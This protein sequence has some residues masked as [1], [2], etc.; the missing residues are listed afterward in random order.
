VDQQ[1]CV[2]QRFDPQCAEFPW[3]TLTVSFSSCNQGTLQF[4]PGNPALASGSMPISRLTMLYNSSCTGG[5]SGDTNA[6]SLSGE[7][8]QFMDNTGLVPAAQGKM[9]FDETVARSEFSVE[10]EDLPAGAYT[11]FVDNVA[12]G[13]INVV[14]EIGGTNGELEFRSPVEPGKVLLDFDPP[15][16]SSRS[17]A[18]AAYFSARR[19][20]P[21][22]RRLRADGFG[23]PP[24]GN[25]EYRLSV[26]PSGNNGPAEGRAGTARR[27]YRLQC[28]TRTCRSATTDW[29]SAA[30][31]REHQCARSRG[32][33]RDRIPQSTGTGHF[34]S[35]SI[36]DSAHRYHFRRKRGDLRFVP[37]DPG[38]SGNGGGTSGGNSGG[39]GGDDHGSGDDD[40]DGDDHGVEDSVIGALLATGAARSPFDARG[41]SRW[42]WMT[43]GTDGALP[44]NCPLDF[45]M[46]AATCSP[47][48]GCAFTRSRLPLARSRSCFSAMCRLS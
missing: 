24:F 45:P 13:T 29:S 48:E 28:R 30:S 40:G 36:R 6:T 41:L 18:A 26:E 37:D 34:G 8:V 32:T 11:L 35:I 44:C 23:S 22:R 25:A 15:G 2:W 39:Q 20:A 21:Q 17:S 1:R 16:N 5:I 42:I 10:A 19:W 3:G 7:I 38:A 33:E 27:S 31:S 43:T 47:R 9:K 12:R 46:F 4:N 14:S